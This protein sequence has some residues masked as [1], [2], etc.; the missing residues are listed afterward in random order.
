M[1]DIISGNSRFNGD[2]KAPVKKVIQIRT[3]DYKVHDAATDELDEEEVK[4]RIR[5]HR[6]RVA[7]IITL[8]VVVIVVILFVIRQALDN[9]SYTSYVITNSVNR[10]DI[11]S[12]QYVTF[13]E[14]Y[15]RYS[16]DGASYYTE[17]G[18]AIWNQTFSMQKPQVKICHDCVAIGDI[19]GNTIYTF[20]KKGLIGKVDT[21]LAISQIEVGKQGAVVAVLED[22]EANYINMYDKDGSKI[23]SVKTT[24]SGDGYPLDISMSEDS[25]RLMASY[26]YVSGEEIKT[27][28]VFY[29]FSNVGKNETERVVGGFNH[30]GDTLVG[31]VQFITNNMAVAVGEDIVSIYRIKEYPSLEKE[32]KIDS[33]IERVFYGDSY[34]GLVLDNSASGELYKLVVY[35]LSG[36]KVCE[37]TFSTQYDVIQFDEKTIIM[38]NS[39][40][41][42]I[43]NIKGKCIADMDFDM[44]STTLL[45]L[46]ERGKYI[47][48]GSKY[49][50]NIKLK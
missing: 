20:D 45:P 3:P 32:M 46:G 25:T 35:N 8:T 29:N 15:I 26:I 18:K 10:E 27:N 1:A 23:Y 39:S 28:V 42:A 7:G 6:L 47:L 37:T 14:G 33:K 12:S 34:I 50:Q 16:N 22:N 31:D 9:Y 21:S 30:Y 17:K 38:N 19:N 24:L 41:F 43:Y 4:H 49:I 44:P 13:G 11:E 48:V 2:K 36:N 40:S 5:R